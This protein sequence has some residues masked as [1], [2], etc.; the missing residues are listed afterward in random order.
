VKRRRIEAFGGQPRVVGRTYAEAAAAAARYAADHGLRN[1]HAYDDPDV[2][3][4]QGTLGLEVLDQVLDVDRVVVAVGGGGL[5]AGVAIA[6]E[7]MAAVTPVEPEQCATL[8]AAVEAGRPVDV[9]VSGV[10]ADSTGATRVGS[11]ALT[12]ARRVRE[13]CRLV[14]DRAVLAAQSALWSACRVVAEPGGAVALAGLRSGVVRPDS[15]ETVVV[16]VC[17][18]NTAVLPEEAATGWVRRDGRSARA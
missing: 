9:P 6:C 12:V 17:G 8:A 2:V 1:I 3:A 14:T 16:V 18:G 4:G 11:I 10:A 13:P 7:G 5:F 15:G